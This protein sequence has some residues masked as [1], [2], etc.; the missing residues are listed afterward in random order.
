MAFIACIGG[1][2]FTSDTSS[3]IF[4]SYFA[5]A[6]ALNSSTLLS[7]DA[8]TWFSVTSHSSPLLL[9]SL[10]VPIALFSTSCNL[11]SNS[12]SCI[13]N[14]FDHSLR[15]EEST[16]PC[17]IWRCLCSASLMTCNVFP[18]VIWNM[19]YGINVKYATTGWNMVSS[20]IGAVLP[21]ATL[22]TEADGPDPGTARGRSDGVP[23]ADNPHFIRPAI[24]IAQWGLT[25]VNRSAL[26]PFEPTLHR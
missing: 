16:T 7:C 11:Y 5:F 20:S 26:N 4:W 21:P 22:G 13:T 1:F 8:W 17:V 24:N 3:T 2:A 19:E 10:I 6:S 25:T 12:W 23:I 14:L 9:S 18:L 15:I